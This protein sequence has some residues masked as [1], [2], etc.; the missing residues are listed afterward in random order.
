METFTYE[1][2]PQAAPPQPAPQYELKKDVTGKPPVQRGMQV[3]KAIRQDAEGKDITLELKVPWPPKPKCNECYGR[4][5]VG[6]DLKKGGLVSC[7]RCY[8]LRKMR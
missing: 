5:Y 1:P 6:V 4:G 3:L 8:P 7:H 2:K